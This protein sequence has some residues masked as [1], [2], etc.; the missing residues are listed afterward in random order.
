[1]VSI[2]NQSFAI[3][4]VAERPKKRNQPPASKA[5]GAA[6]SFTE[7]RWVWFR[8]TD[9]TVER[10]LRERAARQPLRRCRTGL[11]FTLR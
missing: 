9:S 7:R 2:R 11:G 10:L 8:T 6:D 3:C 5:A 4:L 1:M